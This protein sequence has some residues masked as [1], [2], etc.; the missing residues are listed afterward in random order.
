MENENNICCVKDQILMELGQSQK[1]LSVQELHNLVEKSRRGISYHAIHKAAKNLLKAGVVERQGKGY[2]LSKTWVEKVANYLEHVHHA[3]LY[4]KP[5]HLPGLK[6]F[7]EEADTRI[8]IFDNLEE[9]DA[10][11]KQLQ[12]EYLVSKGA[13][14]PYCAMNWHLRSSLFSSERALNIMSMATKTQSKA[15]MI[16]AGSTPIDEWCADYYRNQFVRVQTAIPCAPA[17]DVMVLGDTVVQLY[18]P[19]ELKKYIE[20]IYLSARNVSDINI[21]E[22]YKRAYRGKHDIKLVVI[23]NPEIARQ[24][25]QQIMSNFGYDKIAFFDVNGTLVNGFLTKLFAE[26]LTVNGKFDKKKWEEIAL[27]RAAEK[28][29]DV[30]HDR[31]VSRVIDLYAEGLKGQSVEEIQTL[32]HKF[33]EEGRVPLFKPSR[34]VFNW[35]N[36]YYK[37]VAVTKTPEELMEAVR[38]VFAFDDL[39]ASQLEVKNGKYTGKIKRRLDSRTEKDKAMKA[40]LNESKANLEGSVAFGN[41][42]HDFAF[43]ELVKKPFLIG[44]PDPKTALIAKRRGWPVFNESTDAYDIIEAIRSGR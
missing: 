1:A 38:A 23:K 44:N 19:L 16:V 14:E 29:G 18:L 20:S 17:C 28:S 39:I 42:H 11:R 8:F 7:K 9:A 6:E 4:K 15:F 27:M 33:V 32:A 36:S 35:V 26:H 30:L 24:L 40:W 3:Y 22:F 21:P 5:I 34:R 31:Y 37:T 13:K 43:L 2:V 10:Y 41:L 25:R 12:W